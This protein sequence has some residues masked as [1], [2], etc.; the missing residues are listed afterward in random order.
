M[1][2]ILGNYIKGTSPKSIVLLHNT[3][4]VRKEE[5]KKDKLNNFH[6]MSAKEGSKV[7]K[8]IVT[9]TQ[10]RRASGPHY[11]SPTL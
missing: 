7:Q 8:V 9:V 10:A 5:E 3:E 6:S 11:N 1:H 4:S 2:H